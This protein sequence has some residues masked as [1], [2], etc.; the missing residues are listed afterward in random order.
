M[1]HGAGNLHSSGLKCFHNVI[2][3]DL[4]TKLPLFGTLTNELCKGELV[5]L[6]AQTLIA[7][8]KAFCLM[9]RSIFH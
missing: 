6:L 3:N 1:V 9:A 4:F 8:V 2:N 5:T 7:P